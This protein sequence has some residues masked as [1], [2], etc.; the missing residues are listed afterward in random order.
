MGEGGDCGGETLD[1]G[2]GLETGALGIGLFLSDTGLGE[3]SVEDGDVLDVLE[4]LVDAC[5]GDG[6]V[7]VA[8]VGDELVDEL[9]LLELV[10]HEGETGALKVKHRE[11][12][13]GAGG[14]LRGEG[15][16]V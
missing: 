1:G 4:E 16:E 14:G 6:G 5:L 3:T 12:R 11:D 9:F 8:D 7:G 10:A 13:V 2:C 15:V